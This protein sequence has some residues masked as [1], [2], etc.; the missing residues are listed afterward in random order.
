[1]PLTEH[2][3]VTLPQIADRIARYFVP[4]IVVAALVTCL[5]WLIAGWAGNL[6]KWYM[7]QC[8][9]DPDTPQPDMIAFMFGVVV[10]VVA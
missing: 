1:M 2:Q 5:V 3:C 10:L 9:M 4:A 7:A 6:P 8:S